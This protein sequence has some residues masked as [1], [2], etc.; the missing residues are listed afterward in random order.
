MIWRSEEIETD[1]WSSYLDLLFLDIVYVFKYYII[2]FEWRMDVYFHS[3]QLDY[4]Q[5]YF[6]IK[7]LSLSLISSCPCRKTL[8]FQSEEIKRV[9]PL[10]Q[11]MLP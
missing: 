1:N 8:C 3:R 9:K 10:L 2:R 6:I 4:V 5:E 7:N 11:K